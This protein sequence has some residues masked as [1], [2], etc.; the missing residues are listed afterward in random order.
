M[1]RKEDIKK[2]GRKAWVLTVD[3]VDGW[4]ERE[5]ERGGTRRSSLI[6]F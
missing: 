2:R 4:N 3:K 5:R 6:G 1:T